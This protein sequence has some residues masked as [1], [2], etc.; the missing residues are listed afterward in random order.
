MSSTFNTSTSK[1]SDLEKK[2]SFIVPKYQ[3]RYR[4]G[5]EHCEQ[6][7]DDILNIFWGDSDDHFFNS[8]VFIKN[9]G[10]K[11]IVD[12]QQR[13]ITTMLLLKSKTDIFG[14]NFQINENDF[15]LDNDNNIKDL[16]KFLNNLSSYGL[17]NVQVNK[18]FDDDIVVNKNVNKFFTTLFYAI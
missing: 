10:S 9:N 16:S 2:I 8:K 15:K 4:W 1:Y 3:R 6:F 5:T 18:S 7:L 12:G 17:E 11:T 14:G 13:L